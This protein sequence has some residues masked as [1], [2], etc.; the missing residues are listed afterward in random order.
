[1]RWEESLH[2]DV[3]WDQTNAPQEWRWYWGRCLLRDHR[4]LFQGNWRG[5]HES[6]KKLKMKSW[7]ESRKRDSQVSRVVSWE[8]KPKH[9]HLIWTKPREKLV[10]QVHSSTM[11][12]EPMV[13]LLTSSS[14]FKMPSRKN[15]TNLKLSLNQR[16][17]SIS[18][19]QS[20]TCMKLQSSWIRWWSSTMT[21][22]LNL[23]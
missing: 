10:K 18:M 15:R 3:L 4:R 7:R 23:T 12:L 19:T 16:P 17:S 2:Q 21:S 5:L 9:R 13:Q 8:K 6:Q 11:L 1:M 20:N 14:M 22:L